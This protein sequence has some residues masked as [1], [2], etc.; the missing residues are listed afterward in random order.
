MSMSVALLALQ[1]TACV[2]TAVARIH[3]SAWSLRTQLG[4]D[5]KTSVKMFNLC[6]LNF[7]TALK[8]CQKEYIF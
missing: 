4:V 3:A 5:Y 7:I 6:A 1:L 8:I 2:A